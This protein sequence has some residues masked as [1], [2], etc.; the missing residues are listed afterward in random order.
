MMSGHIILGPPESGTPGTAAE[1]EALCL[2]V[3]GLAASATFSQPHGQLHS[4]SACLALSCMSCR[5]SLTIAHICCYVP[6]E[7]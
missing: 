4:T 5:R 3:D 6:V 1:E 2:Y 7:A